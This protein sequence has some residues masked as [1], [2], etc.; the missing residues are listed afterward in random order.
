MIQHINRNKDKNQLVISIDMENAFNITQHY[1]MIKA[2]RKL[3][4]EGMYLNIIKVIQ[5]KP[6]ANMILN[7]EKLNNFP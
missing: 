2:L 1:F 5:D 4:I 7:E 6:I 3:G